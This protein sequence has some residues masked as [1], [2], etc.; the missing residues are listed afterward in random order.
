MTA[1][2][3]LLL[4]SV[5]IDITEWYVLL[6]EASCYVILRLA[7]FFLSVCLIDAKVSFYDKVVLKCI[8][9]YA[10]YTA[11]LFYINS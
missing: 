10:S 5:D 11:L 6:R 7:F 8:V 4:F 1:G 3:V 2:N 9:Y